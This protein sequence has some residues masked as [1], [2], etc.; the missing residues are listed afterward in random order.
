[1]GNKA[2][3]A[4][5]VSSIVKITT[6]NGLTG[7]GEVVY[8]SPPANEVCEGHVLTCVCHSVKEG[9]ILACIAGLQAHTRG[10]VEGSGL[11]VLQ[12][13]TQ[14]G[15]LGVWPGGLQANTG[16]V[17]QAHTRGS[18]GPHPGGGGLQTHTQ[19]GGYPSMH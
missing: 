18:Q 7:Y 2:R 17:L 19:R 1:M 15:S 6:D 8:L 14:G 10:E 12:A 5:M 4:S 16:G 11:G 13:H 3:G 9:G